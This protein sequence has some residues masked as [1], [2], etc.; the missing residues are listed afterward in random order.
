MKACGTVCFNCSQAT[1]VYFFPSRPLSQFSSECQSQLTIQL[2]I[3]KFNK[4]QVACFYKSSLVI[5][6]HSM[7][8]NLHIVYSYLQCWSDI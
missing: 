7:L 5:L 2:L 4:V 1:A 8:Q 3:S 6:W